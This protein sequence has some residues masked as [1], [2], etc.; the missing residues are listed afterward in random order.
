MDSLFT[1]THQLNKVINSNFRI[2]VTNKRTWKSQKNKEQTII[3]TFKPPNI[4]TESFT[5]STSFKIY[6]MIARL[7]H[8]ILSQI[9]TNE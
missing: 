3:L 2:T 6:G 5:H 7:S 8:Q 4:F 9:S 1:S